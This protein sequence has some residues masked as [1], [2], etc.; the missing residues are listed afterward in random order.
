[1]MARLLAARQQ[2]PSVIFALMLVVLA[3]IWG[4]ATMVSAQWCDAGESGAV[5][6]RNW[7]SA[8]G[9]SVALILTSI[10]LLVT[11]RRTGEAQRRVA[12]DAAPILLGERRAVLYD[13]RAVAATARQE[14]ATLRDSADELLRASA[15]RAGVDTMGRLRQR[16]AGLYRAWPRHDA[17]ISSVVEQARLAGQDAR[18]VAARLSALSTEIAA[19]L[20]FLADFAAPETPSSAAEFGAHEPALTHL[21]QV[22]EAVGPKFDLLLRDAETLV[23]SA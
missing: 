8:V 11:A 17:A 23:T 3:L 15:N 2:W 16:F 22:L 12:A 19:G 13:L 9:S 20:A 18:Y 14:A 21:K 7:M 10:A 1:M 5:C 4:L 6:F